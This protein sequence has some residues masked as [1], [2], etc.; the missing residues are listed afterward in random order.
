MPLLSVHPHRS[1]HIISSQ[2]THN[3]HGPHDD[4]F[5]KYLAGLESEYEDLRRSGYSGEGFHSRGVRL[6]VGTSHNL[7]PHLAKLKALEAA[8]KRRTKDSGGG[9]RLGGGEIGSHGGGMRQ[10][11]PRE[12]AL[13]VRLS[14]IPVWIHLSTILP[15]LC[16]IP[17]GLT[18]DPT[19][20]RHCHRFSVDLFR[21]LNEG[22]MTTWLARL[23]STLR[24]R[25]R[26]P[27]R[28]A[29]KAKSST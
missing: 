22:S 2:L 28:K 19:P 6:G 26:K 4:A 23:G 24:G 14:H 18:D 3:V 12:L 21:P 20:F 9:R 13:R 25:P 7:P 16:G 17:I 5:Y 1:P 27:L 8:E 29:S 11:T 15:T 10:L